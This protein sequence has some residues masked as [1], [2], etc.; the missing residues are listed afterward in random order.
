MSRAVSQA[1]TPSEKSK[2]KRTLRDRIVLIAIYACAAALLFT[3]AARAES[4]PGTL[5]AMAKT[6]PAKREP[7]R[8]PISSRTE[9][10]RIAREAIE[11]LDRVPSGKRVLLRAMDFWNETSHDGLLRHLAYGPVSRTDAVLTRHYHPETGNEVRERYVTVIL[12]KDQP[13]AEVAMD[14]AHEL[15]HATTSPTWDPYDP[16]LTPARYM[17]AA[18]EASGGE[19]D[20]VFTECE[21]AVSFKQDL[22]LRSSRCDRYLVLRGSDNELSVDRGKIQADF[23]RVGRWETFVRSKLGED[24][25]LFPL[26]SPRAPELYSATGGAPY[27]VA[28]MREYEELN[29]VACENVRKRSRAPAS[30]ESGSLGDRCRGMRFSSAQRDEIAHDAGRVKTKP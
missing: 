26:L 13:L 19:I 10:A 24:A 27:P 14:L 15:T 28:L 3:G 8:T 1:F 30:I 4:A 22:D 21:V 7:A 25:T 5:F 20:A 16:K 11:L 29:R 6:E 2:S 23:Y 17:H 12:R 9:S 18:L